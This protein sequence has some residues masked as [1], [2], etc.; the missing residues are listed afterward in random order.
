MRRRV[1]AGA[2]RAE[3]F[4]GFLEGNMFTSELGACTA[5]SMTMGKNVPSG[6]ITSRASL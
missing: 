1:T 4:V 2:L 5:V 3:S 6:R